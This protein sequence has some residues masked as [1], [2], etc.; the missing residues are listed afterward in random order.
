MT[1]PD[2]PAEIPRWLERRVMAPDFGLFVAELQA[3]FPAEANAPCQALFNRWLPVALAEGF[4]SIPLNALSQLLRHPAELA[5]VQERIVVDGGAYWDEVAE[6]SDE[7]IGAVENGRQSLDRIFAA[8]TASTRAKRSSPPKS[9]TAM[10]ATPSGALKQEHGRGYK[11]WA[12]VST[13]IAACLVVA[14][15]LLA[16]REPA[17][18]R[19]PKA[20]IAWGW[21][22]PTGLAADQSNAKSYLNK[23]ADNV[24]EWSLD[25]PS[26]RSGVGMRI[27]ELRAGCTRLIHSAYGPLAADDKKWL[28]DHCREWAKKFDEHQQQLDGG[29]DPILVRSEMDETVRTIAA[30][31]RDKAKQIG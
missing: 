22:K 3:H 19:V 18:I 27:S 24:E 16:F 20:Q 4:D 5:A 13:G 2:D 26:D 6:Q 15:G 14:L 28:L 30:A 29:A 12:Y 31:L 23:L 21:G 17:E 11:L 25:R 7:L 9:S 1:V 10:K 8:N